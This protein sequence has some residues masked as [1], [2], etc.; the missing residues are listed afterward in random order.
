MSI[1][2]QKI[3]ALRVRNDA[4][5]EAGG[6][7]DPLE[8]QEPTA[9]Y[10]AL[11]QRLAH[12]TWQFARQG[13]AVAGID[14]AVMRPI[15]EANNTVTTAARQPKA[16]PSSTSATT[17]GPASFPDFDRQSNELRFDFHLNLYR[18]CAYRFLSD[19][20]TAYTAV[21]LRGNT[22][23]FV[24]LDCVKAEGIQI[25]EYMF[26]A[27]HAANTMHIVVADVH[28]ISIRSY[29]AGTGQPDAYTRVV[30]EVYGQLSIPGDGV[31]T[32]DRDY[33][34]RVKFLVTE[35]RL[36]V[37]F[38]TK[39]REID[40]VFG[41]QLAGWK[42]ELEE[43]GCRAGIWFGEGLM[44]RRLCEGGVQRVDTL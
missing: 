11:E 26:N 44:A 35:Q 5:I 19:T 7:D 41:Q 31:N 15:E 4:L 39:S 28:N 29:G 3:S 30:G 6:S 12:Q 27:A 20:R 43:E 23:N 14:A 32:A 21:Y 34:A 25:R 37:K 1:V 17:L 22:T 36:P 18:P 13:H 8:E 24:S 42:K 38:D 9:Q 2:S 16:L 40:L 10:K 33:G